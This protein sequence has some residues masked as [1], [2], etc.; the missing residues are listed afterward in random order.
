MADDIVMRA[1]QYV[2][3]N[4]WHQGADV[5]DELADEI[6]RLRAACD[7][8]FASVQTLDNECMRLRAALKRIVRIGATEPLA[9]PAADAMESVARDALASSGESQAV[10]LGAAG[11]ADVAPCLTCGRTAGEELCLVRHAREANVRWTRCTSYPACPCGGEPF[12][13][14]DVKCARCGKAGTTAEFIVEE[15]DEWECPPCWEREEARMRAADQQG[16]GHGD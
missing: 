7:R 16:E 6:E 4:G 14:D 5:V 15:G 2:E 8:E 10:Q 3:N 13:P 1:R 11:P 12:Q 9:K